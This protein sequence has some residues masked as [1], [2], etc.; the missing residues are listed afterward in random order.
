MKT[1]KDRL[2]AL[3]TFAHEIWL[4]AYERPDLA[5]EAVLRDVR[6]MSIDSVVALTEPQPAKEE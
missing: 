3:A 5:A 2:A 6:L 4:G 1:D